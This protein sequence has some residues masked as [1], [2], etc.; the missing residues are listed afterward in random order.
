MRPALTHAL[1]PL[2]QLLCPAL[3]RRVA[4]ACCVPRARRACP[5]D[6][7]YSC[8]GSHPLCPARSP[9]PCPCSVGHLIPNAQI[10]VCEITEDTMLPGEA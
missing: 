10:A 6:C 1:P 2:L 5:T 8:P 3:Q 7:I 4:H 9:P